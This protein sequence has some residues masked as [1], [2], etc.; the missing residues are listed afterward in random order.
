MGRFEFYQDEKMT[1]WFRTKFYVEAESEEQAVEI[2]RKACEDATI[3]CDAVGELGQEQYDCE[4]LY[5]TA[6]SMLVEENDG[7]ATIEV[8]DIHNNVIKCNGKY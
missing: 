2:V 6:E 5:Y 1:I 8:Y 7:C 4:Y 3:K